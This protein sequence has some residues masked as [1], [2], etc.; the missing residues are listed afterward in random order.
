VQEYQDPV[1]TGVFMMSRCQHPY[2]DTCLPVLTSACLTKRHGPVPA[3]CY[4]PC[5][6]NFITSWI[7]VVYLFAYNTSCWTPHQSPSPD[8]FL[9]T[10]PSDCTN[11]SRLPKYQYYMPI[12]LSRLLPNLPCI[13]DILN[14]LCALL[15]ILQYSFHCLNNMP[16]MWSQGT[17]DRL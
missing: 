15:R 8:A 7:G 17:G 13:S 14:V 4:P 10:H 11:F 5:L 12:C 6:P 9:N 16:W 2:P 1:L 3:K